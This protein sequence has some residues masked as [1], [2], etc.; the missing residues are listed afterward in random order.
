MD[1]PRYKPNIKNGGKIP[2]FLDEKILN[3]PWTCGNCIVCRKRKAREWNLR[4]QQDIKD[5]KHA[6][7]VTLTFSNE[8]YTELYHE[9]EKTIPQDETN[10]FRPYQIDNAIAKRAVRRFLERW[11]KKYKKSV[12]H[13]LTTELGHNNTEH[14]HLH[15]IIYTEHW[16]DIKKIWGY[17]FVWDG[18]N[19]KG[20]RINYVTEQTINY[21]TKY[22]NKIDKKHQLYKPIILCTQGIGAGYI[23]TPQA[24]LNKFNF[25]K[26]NDTYTTSTG[27][28]I[29][30]PKYWK[31]KL[32]TDEEREMLWLQKLELPYSYINKERFEKSLGHEE[33]LKLLK[34]HR[35]QNANLG[36]GSY[37]TNWKRAKYEKEIRIIKQKAKLNASG[38][39]LAQD[40]L[41]TCYTSKRTND[42]KC[43][44]KPQA[45]A[46]TAFE[47][48]KFE[49]RNEHITT[50]YIINAHNKLKKENPEKFE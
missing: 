7:F 25:D 8:S 4:L 40:I 2:A 17:G 32:Y 13:W 43:A 14:I 20:K 34:W 15:G 37:K 42:D 21:I 31:N 22:V 3:V 28:K 45:N 5:H 35:E 12:R 10:L 47:L 11:R 23:K 41:D 27:H 44:A 1:N 48:T 38:G 16:Q 24:K 19:Q 33:Y 29:A 49:R 9:V 46:E 50:N 26:T 30:L 36:Y 18:Y 6:Q 39:V